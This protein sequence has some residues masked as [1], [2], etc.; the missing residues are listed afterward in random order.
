VEVPQYQ[1]RIKKM[2]VRWYNSYLIGSLD[3]QNFRYKVDNPS[4]VARTLKAI[5]FSEDFADVVIISGMHPYQER[6]YAHRQILAASSE[7]FQKMLY[8]PFVEGSKREVTI[9]NIQPKILKCLLQFIYTGYVQ[10]DTDIIVP[11]IQAADQYSVQ[12][13]KEEF[14]KA[15]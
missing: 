8:G 9:P 1:K 11:L 6:I 7:V 4:I 13:A 15:A 12:G 3:M 10:I 2:E 5:L 14:G